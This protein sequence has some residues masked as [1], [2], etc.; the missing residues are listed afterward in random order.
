MSGSLEEPGVS[1]V[2]DSLGVSVVAVVPFPLL[3]VAG[4]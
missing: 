2:S 1:E 3:G 4:V